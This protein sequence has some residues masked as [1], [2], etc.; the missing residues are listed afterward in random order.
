[1]QHKLELCRGQLTRVLVGMHV[2]E[3]VGLLGELHL[4]I[5]I[6]ELLHKEGV[7]LPHNLPN[8]I[9]WNRGHF[10]SPTE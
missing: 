7:V 2:V 1:M 3:V 6:A 9:P 8:Q 5:A 4:G 10:P